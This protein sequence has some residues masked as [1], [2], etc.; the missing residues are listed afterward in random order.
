MKIDNF[1]VNYSLLLDKIAHML[2]NKIAARFLLQYFSV[3][4]VIDYIK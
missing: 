3:T 2:C 1:S 4:R